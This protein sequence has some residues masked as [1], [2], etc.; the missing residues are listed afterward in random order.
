MTK[1]WLKALCN[2]VPH[3]DKLNSAISLRSGVGWGGGGGGRGEGAFT[4]KKGR[5]VLPEARYPYSFPDTT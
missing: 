3:R 4:I 2:E 1:W 5:G